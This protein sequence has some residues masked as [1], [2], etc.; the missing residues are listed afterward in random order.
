[1][2]YFFYHI[3]KT[4]G[5][6]F[7]RVLEVW[8]ETA[9]DEDMSEADR[10]Q[11]ATTRPERLCIHGHFGASLKSNAAS[12]IERYPFIVGNPDARVITLLREPIELAVSYYFHEKR[13]GTTLPDLTVFLSKPLPV[14]LSAALDV[15]CSEEI[16]AML[17][18]FWFVGAGGDLQAVADQL[19]E[20]EGWPTVQVPVQ[21]RGVIPTCV[22]HHP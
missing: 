3:P 22:D 6:S 15:R 19:S 4:A 10:K 18:S 20:R 14:S 12:L 8:L 9:R 5:T 16:D 13:R 1:M 17:S 11:I 2:T 7:K 21:N